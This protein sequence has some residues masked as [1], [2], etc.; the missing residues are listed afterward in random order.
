VAA[1]GILGAWTVGLLFLPAGG[2]IAA[3][4]MTTDV[5]NQ[6]SPGVHLGVFTA[7]ALLQAGLML[8]MARIF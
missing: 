7:A 2:V 5:R 6:G 4:A 1:F 3:A 8:A